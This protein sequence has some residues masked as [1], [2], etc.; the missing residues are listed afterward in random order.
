[1]E[2]LIIL[3]LAINIVVLV[4]ICVGMFRDAAWITATWGAKSPARS[5]LFSVYFAIL[6]ASVF[7]CFVPNQL[8]VLSLLLVQII[9]KVSTPLTVGSIKHPVVASNLVI[10]AIHLVTALTI[11]MATV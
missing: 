7:L 5:I 8:M 6:C 11:V 1:M 10:S 2:T 3:S 9:Y 4:P